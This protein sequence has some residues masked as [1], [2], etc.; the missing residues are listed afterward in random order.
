MGCDTVGHRLATIFT[1]RPFNLAIPSTAGGSA[2]HPPPCRPAE[3]IE[4]NESIILNLN[5]LHLDYEYVMH[6]YVGQ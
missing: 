1:F 4:Q 3:T 5:H 6:C 2:R